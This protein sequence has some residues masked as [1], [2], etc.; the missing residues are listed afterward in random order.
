MQNEIVMVVS[1]GITDGGMKSRSLLQIAVAG[2]SGV[3]IDIGLR[4]NPPPKVE[5]VSVES[6]ERTDVGGVRG[7]VA[8]DWP[9]WQWWKAEYT[10]LRIG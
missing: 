6:R 1:A 10:R 8:L 3:N 4:G 2:P 9:S 5:L 7:N